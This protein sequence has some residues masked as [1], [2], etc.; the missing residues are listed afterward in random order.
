V[1]EI[2]RV[3][4]RS[5]R[6]FV[7]T[8]VTAAVYASAVAAYAADNTPLHATIRAAQRKVVKIYGAGGLKGLEAYQSG[9]V[10]SP[11][12]HVLTALSYVLDSDE[13]AVVLDDGRR[14]Q[15]ELLGVD[16][17]SELAVLKLPIEDESLP[18]F[19]LAEAVS[20]QVGDR[21]LALSNLY[22]IAGG[23]EPASVLQGVVA[24]I[25]P[26]EA[27]RGGYQSNFHGQVYLLDAAANN[28]GAAGGALV[29]WNGRLLGVLG[30][31]LKSR[32]TG[33]WIHYA[34]PIDQIAATVD[35]LREGQSLDAS[36]DLPKPLEALT[37]ADLGLVL[38]P[39]VLPRTPPYIDSVFPDSPAA[40][41]DLRPDD[42]VVF[43]DAEPTTSCQSVIE[44]VSRREK[45]DELRISVL[46]DGDFI[47]A[48]LTAD[49]LDDDKN[50]EH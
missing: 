43:V 6:I 49:D 48:T 41:A 27:R 38:V 17:V 33:A 36:K 44:T 39:D 25:A 26:L 47:E 31:E 23:D 28:P 42:L 18:A 30:K 15:P 11:E 35:R 5:Q 29:D 7:A 46:R 19:N 22:N 32:S 3:A 9:I 24:A 2:H 45:F 37:L 16:Q 12:G 40:R 14:F 21:I 10:I 50:G 4:P 8:L 34:L 13:M 20:A 1:L